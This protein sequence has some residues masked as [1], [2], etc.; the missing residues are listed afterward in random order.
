VEIA[1]RG[2]PYRPRISGAHIVVRPHMA[3]ALLILL[4]VEL[5]CIVALV[6][7]TGARGGD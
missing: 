2:F 6:Q 5:G 4:V 1:V 3:T 7:L